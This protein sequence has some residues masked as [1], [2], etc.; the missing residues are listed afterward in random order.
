MIPLSA[1]FDN[2]AA[3]S[4]LDRP[5]VQ[6]GV[7]A[8]FANGH[9]HNSANDDATMSVGGAIGEFA[10][11]VP[12]GPV[13]FALG[14][15]PDIALRDRWHYRDAPG[16][17]DGITTYGVQ[18]D[19]AEI[20]LLRSALGASWQVIPTVSLGANVGFLYNENRLQTPYVFQTQPV[21]RTVKTLLD[22][23]TDGFGWNA[24]VALRWQPVSSL[25]LSAVYTSQ[26]TIDTHGRATGDA[27]VQLANLGL[28]AARRDFKYDAEVENVFPQQVSG[29]LAW[30]A[31]N[32]LTLS[33]QFDWIEWSDAFEALPVRLTHGNNAD[34]NGL[35]GSRRLND[36][37]PLHW[38]DQ[39]VGR[40][41]VEQTLGKGWMLRAGYA[42]GNNP[43]PAGTLTPLNAPIT[44]HLLTAGVG[45]R[46]GRVTVDAA[47]QWQVPATA[48]VRRSDLAAGEY[49]DSVTEIDVQ[50]LGLTT[51][52]G[53]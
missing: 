19:A 1:L 38:R 26:A 39:Y 22:L 53:F 50:Y 7:D 34:L 9:F 20:L 27:G 48:R 47:Y 2:P 6:L 16:G 24:Q 36:N 45:F 8:A 18:L 13:H 51:T 25:T 21:L 14:L 37:V 11:T 46:K 28:G 3:L 15:N 10:A 5:A 33:A 12:L 29:G 4:E 30:R 40:W 43:V 44:E 31:T 49:S 52:I 42:Y 35:V 23:Q 41:G 17:A 32:R